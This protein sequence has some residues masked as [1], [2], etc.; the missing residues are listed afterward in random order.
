[1]L[2][3]VAQKQA[4]GPELL[5]GLT[6]ISSLVTEQCRP[7]CHLPPTHAGTGYQPKKPCGE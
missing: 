2:D 1:M 5:A 6:F 4:N 3:M 7:A